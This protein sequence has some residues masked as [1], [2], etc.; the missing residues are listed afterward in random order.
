MYTIIGGDGKEYGPISADD[1]RKWIAE[2]RLN[3]Q[4][5]AKAE[6]DAEFRALATFPEFAD[7]LAPRAPA[8]GAPSAFPTGNGRDT[9]AQ[10]IKIPAIAL[11]VIA[12]LGIAYYL[13][14]G[15][16]V[17]SG[18]AGSSQPDLPA[19]APDWMRTF[20]ENA[21]GPVAGVISLVIAALDGFVLFG[22]IKMMR[23]QS[24][25][26]AVAAAIISMVPCQ[27]CC[28]F[29]LPFGIWALVVLNRPDVK[30]HFHRT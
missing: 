13:F 4:S 14:N 12:S 28:L 26:L 23:L 17:L 2:G 25:G 9:A 20:M 16:Y 21:R 8:P 24:F 1:L 6:S 15:A 29:G 27:C 3:G 22:A 30:L 10:A 5:L 7:V 11:I 18:L 19:N